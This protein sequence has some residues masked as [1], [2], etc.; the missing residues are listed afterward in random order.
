MFDKTY[1][2]LMDEMLDEIPDDVDKREGS[3][4]YDAVAPAALKLAEFYS[5]L[6][7]FL[8]LVFADTADG[9]YLTRRAAEFGIYRRLAKSAIRK[10]IFKDTDG[11]PLDIPLESRFTFEDIN[12]VVSEKIQDGEYKLEAETPGV[13]GN[14]GLGTLLPVEP[15]DNLGTAELTD[16]LTPGTDE[17]T[18][19]SLYERLNIRVQKQATSGNVY[20]YEQWA[21]SVPGVGGAKIIPTWNGPGTVKVIL[22][23]LNK[24]PASQGV[25]EAVYEYIEEER[26]I[27][28]TVTVIAASALP[29]N[30]SA[31]IFL[32]AGATKQEAVSQFTDALKDYLGKLA[33]KNELIRY[34]R[35]ANLL[36]DIPSI[37]DYEDLLVNGSTSNIEPLGGNVGVTGTVIFLE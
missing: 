27:G 18:D 1:E 10:G 15:I 36:I 30:V 20:H 32:A 11:L 16:V 6:N 8:E 7:A 2:D 17:E 24:Q 29:I 4:I 19:E 5:D 22:I 33:F 25:V 34:S 31:N 13:V 37:V 23:D 35:I 21:L 28:A 9:E 12:F 3:I 26:P 14:V